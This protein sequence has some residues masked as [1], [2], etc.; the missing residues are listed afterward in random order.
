MV[1]VAEEERDPQQDFEQEVHRGHM[2]ALEHGFK[3]LAFSTVGSIIGGVAGGLIIGMIWGSYVGEL[4]Q[5]ETAGQAGNA[6]VIGGILGAVLGAALAGV[7]ACMGGALAF[8]LGGGLKPDDNADLAY[9]K[10]ITTALAATV[11]ACGGTIVGALLLPFIGHFFGAMFAAAIGVGV[12][13]MIGK[14]WE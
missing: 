13:S 1:A 8:V 2:K 3:F 10:G 5:E 11:C 12:G 6:V 7:G 9:I 14:L 4:M